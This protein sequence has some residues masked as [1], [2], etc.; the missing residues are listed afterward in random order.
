[1]SAQLLAV[2]ALNDRLVTADAICRSLE[3]AGGESAPAWVWMFRGQIDAIGAAAEALE[4]LVRRGDGGNHP[5][6]DAE[7]DQSPGLPRG[8]ADADSRPDSVS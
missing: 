7:L 5:H 6:G 3:L 4:Q 1:M 2:D 8:A